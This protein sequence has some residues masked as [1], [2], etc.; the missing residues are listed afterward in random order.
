MVSHAEAAGVLC[1]AIM[2]GHDHEAADV[3]F[4]FLMEGH[5]GASDTCA[6][7]GRVMRHH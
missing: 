5:A 7:K 4:L 1:R 3:L 2:G 6:H